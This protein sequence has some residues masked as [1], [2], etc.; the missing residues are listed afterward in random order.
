LRK[1]RNGRAGRSLVVQSNSRWSGRCVK[2]ILRS[3]RRKPIGESWGSRNARR[4][5]NELKLGNAGV[6]QRR[7]H[8]GRSGN[9][10]LLG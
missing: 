1:Q 10:V 5:C 4:T 9:A 8:G 6:L 2:V 7:R 3:G